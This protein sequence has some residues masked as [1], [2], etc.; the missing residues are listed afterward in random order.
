MATTCCVASR[1]REETVRL[2]EILGALLRPGDVVA[3]QGPLG[4]GKTTFVQGLSRGLGV[5][6]EA[7]VTSPT[8]TLVAEYPGRVPLRHADF[9]RVESARR[10]ADAGFD[11]LLD[12][13]GVLVVEWPERFPDALPP[14]RLWIRLEIRGESERLLRLEG[15]GERAADLARA[16]ASQGEAWD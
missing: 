2:G 16:L 8:F 15:A 12:G 9:Y 13:D 4:A 10:L 14:E 5:P 6:P 11:D 1:S 3:L 7:A